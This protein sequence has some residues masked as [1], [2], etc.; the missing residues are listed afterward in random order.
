MLP[1]LIELARVAAR[2]LEA[3]PNPNHR[4]ASLYALAKKGV[5]RY[6]AAEALQAKWS[7]DLAASFSATELRVASS[8]LATLTERLRRQ[9]RFK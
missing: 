8:V 1:H 7:N 3:R 5:Q 2:L 4:R 6:A 9:V